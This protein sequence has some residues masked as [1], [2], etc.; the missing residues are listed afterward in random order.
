MKA[1]T[2]IPANVWSYLKTKDGEYYEKLLI[3]KISKHGS[4]YIIEGLESPVLPISPKPE[5]YYTVEDCYGKKFFIEV[6]YLHGHAAKNLTFKTLDGKEHNLEIE[7]LKF[8][9]EW[10]GVE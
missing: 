7:K 8:L 1:G 3:E 4:E 10:R 9:K 2:L 6:L 5:C